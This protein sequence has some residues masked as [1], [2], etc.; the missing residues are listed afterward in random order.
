MSPAPI[1]LASVTSSVVSMV[2]D[3]RPSTSDGAMPASRRAATTASAA[4]WGSG[5]SIDLA[6]SVCPIPTMAAASRSGLEDDAIDAY[7]ARS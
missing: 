5:R 6:N 3:D 1:V 7:V 4:S 2:N